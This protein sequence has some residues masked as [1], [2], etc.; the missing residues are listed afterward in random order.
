MHTPS[1]TAHQDARLLTELAELGVSIAR[2]IEARVQEA[3]SL[4]EAQGL[5]LAFHRVSRGVRLSL[6]L[7]SRL[8]REGRAG[9]EQAHVRAILAAPA[10]KAQ[11]RAAITREVYAEYEAGDAEALLDELEDRLEEEALD[12]GFAQGPVE[13]CIA[14][15]RALLGLPANDG[16]DDAEA[17][18]ALRAVPSG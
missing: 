12:D 7:K 16:A 14:R 3:K 13:A 8:E 1:D 15:I 17:P 5:A 10:R 9:Q 18:V 4:Q 6:A 2:A 11:V